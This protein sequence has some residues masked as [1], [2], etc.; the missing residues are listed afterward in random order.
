MLQCANHLHSLDLVTAD[1]L[2]RLSFENPLRFIGMAPSDLL[3]VPAMLAVDADGVYRVEA[4]P[5]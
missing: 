3:P 2:R 1:E 4:N 5:H